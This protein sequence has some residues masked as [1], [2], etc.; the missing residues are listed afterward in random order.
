MIRTKYGGSLLMKGLLLFGMPFSFHVAMGKAAEAPPSFITTAYAVSAAPTGIAVGNLNRDGAPH[1]STI[2]GTDNSISLPAGKSDNATSPSQPPTENV[3][4]Q[5]SPTESNGA[6]NVQPQPSP[7]ESN[8]AGNV[9][10]QP[11]PTENSGTGNVQ[12]QPSPVRNSGTGN[13]QPQPSLVNNREIGN[14]QPQPS[15]VESD[16]DSAEAVISHSMVGDM[17]MT[18]TDVDLVLPWSSPLS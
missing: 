9:Q 7:T 14:V 15:P 1:I 10:P 16:I 6:G 2:D 17:P 4:P 18:S 3:Q 13:V 5:P 12:P 8:G 11:S